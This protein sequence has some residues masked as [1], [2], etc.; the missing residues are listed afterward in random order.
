MEKKQ[1]SIIRHLTDSPRIINLPCK[2]SAIGCMFHHCS[3]SKQASNLFFS[4]S[5]NRR[6]YD[7]D[8]EEYANFSIILPGT[9]IS[10]EKPSPHDEIW[11]AYPPEAA[12]FF[13]RVLP[14]DI[15]PG[16]NCRNDSRFRKKLMLTLE[17]AK[18]V[19]QIHDKLDNFFLPNSVDALDMLA[20]Q[21]I[22]EAVIE[23]K[24][25]RSQYSENDLK[26][27]KLAGQLKNGIPL[28]ELIRAYGFSRRNF[29]LSWNRIY[30]I[31]P[32][33]F[34]LQE[35]LETAANL[36]RRTELPIGE[37]AAASGFNSTIYFYNQFRRF[38]GLTPRQYREQHYQD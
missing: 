36:L 38:Y 25:E 20:L 32:I 31:S 33:Q 2:L 4:L 35:N 28:A 5:W 11:L 29:Y 3:H 22:E 16:K 18:I 23:I 9:W 1:H 10:I 24:M 17:L 6:K 7:P 15:F 21:L 27:M 12:D 30:K 8:C 26:I 14:A 19:R 13:S 34:K 37:I